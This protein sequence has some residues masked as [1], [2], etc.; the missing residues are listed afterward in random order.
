MYSFM[1]FESTPASTSLA[2]GFA[3]WELPI[4]VVSFSRFHG[5]NRNSIPG[6]Y[7]A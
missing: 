5:S 6:P 4:K 7:K 2:T 3:L 1:D